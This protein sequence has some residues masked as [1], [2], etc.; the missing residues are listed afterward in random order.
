[1]HP[2]YADGGGGYDTG[3]RLLPV[4]EPSHDA[5]FAPLAHALGRDGTENAKSA[6]AVVDGLDAC[7]I[8][9]ARVLA[10]SGLMSL[11][12][13]DDARVEQRDLD[14]CS[15]FTTEDVVRGRSRAEALARCVNDATSNLKTPHTKVRSVAEADVAE[16]MKQEESEGGF[17]DVVLSTRKD[18]DAQKELNRKCA[19]CDVERPQLE[20][21]DTYLILPRRNVDHVF[22]CALG[23]FAFAF[24]DAGE[25]HDMKSK[26][27]PTSSYENDR[28]FKVADDR[29]VIP[30]VA[31][32]ESVVPDADERR[33]DRGG[34][35]CAATVCDAAAHGLSAG[36]RVEFT[37]V[38][39]FEM[40]STKRSTVTE[41]VN[42]HAFKV[43]L[44]HKY[45]LSGVYT[46]GVYTSGVS[47]LGGWVEQMPRERDVRFDALEETLKR[48]RRIAEDIDAEVDFDFGVVQSGGHATLKFAGEVDVAHALVAEL[49][50]LLTTTRPSSSSS[51]TP[52]VV[53]PRNPGASEAVALLRR[54]AKCEVLPVCKVAGAMAA[55]EALKLITERHVPAKQWLV[56]DAAELMLDGGG[57]GGDGSTDRSKPAASVG[58]LIGAK[59]VDAAN[60]LRVVVA[61]SGDVAREIRSHGVGDVT[62]LEE[63]EE[64]AG[65]VG[66]RWR[67]DDVPRDADVLVTALDDLSSRRA[68]DDLSVRRRVA[69]IDPGADGCRLSCHV[70]IPHV[71]APWSHGPRDAPDWE[72]PSC[73]LGNFPH[74]FA[75]CG[76][77]AR[78][79]YAEIFVAPFRA[80]RAYL[81]S[82]AAGDGFDDDVA[83]AVATERMKDPKAK[84]TEL[85]T[86]RDVLLADAPKT[87]GDC[88]RWAARLFKRLFEDGP[89]EML[90][91][92][93]VDQKTA[94]GAPFWS[95][96][97]RAPKPIKYGG[98]NFHTRHYAS[99]VVA[100]ARARML[101]YGLKPKKEG[102][103]NAETLREM[104]AMRTEL[105]KL[106][107]APASATDDA[108]GA[109]NKKRKREH[110]DD[111]EDAAARAAFDAIA[112]ELSSKRVQISSLR[113]PIAAYLATSAAFAPR[114]PIHAGFVAAA[115][116]S[117]ARVYSIHLGRLEE[118]YDVVSVAADAKPGMPGVN[119]LLAALVAVET[120]KLGALK[121]R[122]AAKPAPTPAPAPAFRNTYASVGANVHVSAAATAL[123][124]TTVATKTGTFRWSVW[125]VIDLGECGVAKGAGDALTLKRVIDAFKEKFG[126]EVGAVSIGPSLLYADFM[127][128][129]KTKDKLER[130]L[131][132]VLTEIGK[133]PPAEEGGG[134]EGAP[135]VAAVQL[136]I[137]AC[138]ENDDDVEGVP[139]VRVL[140]R[141]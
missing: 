101:A 93:P 20:G 89:N 52:I 7:G 11:V 140:V 127:N 25:R 62:T 1:M 87:V 70:A 118:Y 56:Y 100:A 39:G 115:A 72:P 46:S 109:A 74:V 130:P 54:G 88:V 18:I 28:C 32:V 42:P 76:K 21:Q 126:L 78:D 44:E 77:W 139:D 15:L 94:A 135:A 31:M 23:C 79:R 50:A 104:D 45:A 58:E 99:F 96:T 29:V 14:A 34:R 19:E 10:R 134:G 117:R 40:R 49:E 53:D 69:M 61:G 51:P 12:L 131:V 81:D 6:T 98:S 35:G 113:E 3:G 22:A 133:M 124:C 80:A 75:H 122:D 57:G 38:G 47:A 26:R 120:Y 68:F 125:D 60:A 55:C 9:A 16:L 103:E 129:A 102:D 30:P 41:V 36:D 8:E 27:T 111:D 17:V 141:R 108:A 71:T 107:Q 82:S 84:L 132:D 119:A 121:A 116:L 13:V 65:D 90:R 64:G 123:P 105:A 59:T 48:A 128:P 24:V 137:G 33:A 114:D 92:F 110:D 86:I 67:E 4:L 136:S 37:G 5:S 85:A 83:A 138:D 91:S 66:G 2:L 95:G 97:K 73:V 43:D 106:T 112:A 63:R